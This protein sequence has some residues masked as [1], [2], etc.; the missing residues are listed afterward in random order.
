MKE[1]LSEKN[2]TRMLLLIVILLSLATG[3][4]QMKYEEENKKY[5]RLEDKYV[6]VRQQLGRDEMQ[7]LI[8]LSYE[9]QEN[10]VLEK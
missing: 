7:R 1:Y 3:Y 6:R 8:D 5:L 2:L 4:Y 9:E 10:K